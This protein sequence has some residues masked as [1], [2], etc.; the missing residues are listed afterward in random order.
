[1]DL[2]AGAWFSAT[3]RLPSTKAGDL[4]LAIPKLRKGSFFPELLELCRR[5]D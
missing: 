4:Q 5:I 2:P 3:R 1:M